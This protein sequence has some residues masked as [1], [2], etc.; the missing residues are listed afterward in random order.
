MHSTGFY[1]ES[2]RAFSERNWNHRTPIYLKL[3]KG[4]SAGEWKK[5]YAA[6]GQVEESRE[7]LREFSHPVE[8]W[9]D[10]P[11]EYTMRGSD[12][13]EEEEEEEEE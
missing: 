1:I 5:F 10:D 7:K 4:L 8:R 12:P 2:K 3:V 9:A 6:L 13:A 11:E